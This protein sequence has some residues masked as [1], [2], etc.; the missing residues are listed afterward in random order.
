MRI[1]A[2]LAAAALC[3]AAS[4]SACSGDR[5]ANRPHNG[6]TAVISGYYELRNMNPLAT[7]GDLNLAIERYALFTPLVRYDSSLHV[8]PWLAASF[9]T[10]RAG[11]DSLDLTFHLRTDVMWHD[12]IRVTARDVAFTFDIARNPRTAYAN[13]Q[14]FSLYSSPYDVIDS[15]TIRFRL[16]AH[17]DFLEVWFLT[18]PLPSHL[19][20]DVKPEEF[21]R[22][23]FGLAPVGSGPFRFAKRDAGQWTFEANTT[24][25]AALGGRPHL[26]RLVYRA[27]PEQSSV[28]TSLLAGDVD[29]AVSIRPS[30]IPTLKNAKD[31]ALL[32]F[33]SP[34]WIF[35][36]FNTRL[37]FFDTP[38]ERR[39]I[40]MAT[41]RRSI[42][43]AIMGGSNAIGRATV[44]PVHPAYDS[45]LVTAYNPDSAR[46]LLANAGWK[47]RN[48]DGILEDA[49]GRPF[50]FRLKAWQSSG[51]YGDIVQA[52]QAQ[53]K[54]IGVAVVPDIVELNTFTTQMQ[55]ALDPHGTRVHD[56]DA[57]LANWTDNMRKDDSQL[58]HSRFTNGPRD[59][60]GFHTPALDALLDSLGTT[61]DPVASHRLWHDYQRTIVEQAPLFVL[62]YAIGL[63]ATRTTLHGVTAD[64]RGPLAS[65]QDWWTTR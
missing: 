16:R 35:V 60:M 32:Q 43:D 18:P 25:P 11:T 33:P 37:P 48:G 23:P 44:T 4:T 7:S 13:A 27:I 19:L 54:R 24:F 40:A 26:D 64:A 5:A 17:P 34:N 36:A 41:D 9:D 56:F 46:V 58:F 57:A 21:A 20:R 14:A 38:G 10:A 1:A 31:V 42:I 50:Q 30:N 15:A 12:G 59:W 28:I 53:L 2:W 47:D 45:T 51:A 63:N 39:A 22:A 52:M 65:V 6:G 3:A 62:Y 29:L 61:L 49:A 8:T 55:G